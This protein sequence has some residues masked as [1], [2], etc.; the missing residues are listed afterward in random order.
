M[1]TWY[2]RH[3]RPPG[4]FRK[5]EQCE[6]PEHSECGLRYTKGEFSVDSHGNLRL[7]DVPGAIP[8]SGRTPG[9]PLFVTVWQDAEGW[10]AEFAEAGQ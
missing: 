9:D 6:G 8:M 5:A 2:C 3:Y 10:H 4:L 1:S 7:C